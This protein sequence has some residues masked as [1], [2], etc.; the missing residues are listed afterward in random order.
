MIQ[1]NKQKTNKQTNKQTNK[2]TKQLC[3][4]TTLNP[5]QVRSSQNTL[6]NFPLVSQDDYKI[7]KQTTQNK[8]N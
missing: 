7:N 4:S 1:M 6:G 8:K 5:N 3:K 2:K